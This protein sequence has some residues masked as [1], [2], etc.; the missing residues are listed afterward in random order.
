M[1]RVRCVLG[2]AVLVLF[3]ATVVSANTITPPPNDPQIN[4]SDP[5]GTCP[6]VFGTTVTFTLNPL[7]MG[8]FCFHNASN[9]NWNT[10]QVTTPA[11]PAV[12]FPQG[13]SCTSSAFQNCTFALSGGNIVVFFSGIG[14][15]FQGI[16]IGQEIVIDMNGPSGWVPNALVTG[17][18]NI[19]E[20]ATLAL[21]LTGLAGLAARRRHARLKSAVRL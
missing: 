7:G 9:V 5:G 18:A 11:V 15:T 19:P 21:F 1:K 6:R 14:G 20:P 3:A 4:I 17:V 10:F 12:Q 16:R 2:I 13:Y 8:L